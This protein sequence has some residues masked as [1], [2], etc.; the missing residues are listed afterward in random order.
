MH[1]TLPPQIKDI[2]AHNV[3]CF[4]SAS[5]SCHQCDFTYMHVLMCIEYTVQI[6]ANIWRNRKFSIKI[7]MYVDFKSCI[8][9]VLPQIII[10]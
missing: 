2:I 3:A 1:Y 9:S 4:V 8:L 5:V 6:D 10:L 7:Q